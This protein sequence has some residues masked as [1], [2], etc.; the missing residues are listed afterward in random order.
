MET[1]FD[2]VVSWDFRFAG[3]SATAIFYGTFNGSNTI[4]WDGEAALEAMSC[5]HEYLK[6]KH[7]DMTCRV[8]V[9]PAIIDKIRN[10]EI[11]G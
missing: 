9:P 4:E 3:N 5:W 2:H 7:V 8:A 11:L 10:R 1:W 6:T